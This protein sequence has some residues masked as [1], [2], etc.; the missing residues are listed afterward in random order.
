M[1]RKDPFAIGEYYHLY[2]RGTDRRTI[3]LDI[4]D[5]HRFIILLYLCNTDK[6]VNLES[7]FRKGRSFTELFDLKRGA[8]LVSIGAWCLMPNHFHLL[9][10]EIVPGGITKF[11]RKINTGYSMYFNK[12]QDRIGNLFQGRFKSENLY[13]DE[14]LK[15][16]FS[17]IHLNPIKLING[18]SEWKEIGI[19]DKVN[20]KNFLLKYEYSSLGS[21]LNEN[22]LYQKIIS[23]KDFPEYFPNKESVWGEILE[24][25]S[26]NDVKDGPL[27]T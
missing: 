16:I 23:K 14:Y 25:L 20:A 6:A 22:N 26:F 8:P 9:V 11:M 2:N 19:K 3:F 18:E 13:T 5:Y 7:Q 17:Y 15:Y 21:Y 1:L 4:H 24:W 10:K 12:K 27:Q